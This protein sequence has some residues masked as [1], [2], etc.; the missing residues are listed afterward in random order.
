MART[1][2]RKLSSEPRGIPVI[3]SVTGDRLADILI[4]PVLIFVYYVCVD[5]IVP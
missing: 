3:R 2:R 4:R 5:C 1:I